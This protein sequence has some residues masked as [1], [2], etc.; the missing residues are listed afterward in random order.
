KVSAMSEAVA[1][2]APQDFYFNPWD[3]NFRANPYPHYRPLLVGPP[4]VLDMGYKLALAAR[5]ACV[6]AILMDHATFS[7]VLPKGTGFDE[8]TQIFGGARSMLGSG[9]PTQTRLR[10]L[11]SRE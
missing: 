10:R 9:P 8:Q 2:Q 6:R 3:E 4:R 1:P 11:V 5:S 7:G